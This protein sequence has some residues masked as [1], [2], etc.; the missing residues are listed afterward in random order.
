MIVALFYLVFAIMG[1]TL[2]KGEF[3]ECNMSAISEIIKNNNQI[4]E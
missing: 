2:F 3:E 4:K 1:I